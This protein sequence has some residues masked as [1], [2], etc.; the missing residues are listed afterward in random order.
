MNA[1]TATIAAIL[2][3][4]RSNRTKVPQFSANRQ[5]V[6]QSWSDQLS[7]SNFMLD[8]KFTSQHL[9]V[10]EYVNKDIE[11]HNLNI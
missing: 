3:A 10:Y 1:N 2:A 8:F 6:A 11:F 4:P 9:N 7:S 5:A